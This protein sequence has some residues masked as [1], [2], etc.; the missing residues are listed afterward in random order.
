[1]VILLLLLLLLILGDGRVIITHHDN[2]IEVDGLLKAANGNGGET[3][4]DVERRGERG[5]K[6]AQEFSR[7][8]TRRNGSCNVDSHAFYSS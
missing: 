2:E 6:G 8:I 4:G 5:K 3:R 7:G 1:M